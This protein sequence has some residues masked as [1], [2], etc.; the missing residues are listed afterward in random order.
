MPN[1]KRKGNKLVI[2]KEHEKTRIIQFKKHI[3][4]SSLSEIEDENYM[5]F[6][7]IVTKNAALKAINE[8]KALNIP[9]TLLEDGW[10]VRKFQ[11][12]TVEK[13][14]KVESKIPA[15][16]LHSLTKGSILHVKSN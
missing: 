3:S 16:K 4:F 1:P 11:D 7:D 8:N 15:D 2:K 9:V 5:A 10:V 12:G 14:K 6:W 13:V